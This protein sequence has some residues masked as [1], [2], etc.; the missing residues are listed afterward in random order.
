MNFR[1]FSHSQPDKGRGLWIKA[2]RKVTGK[3][4]ET[5]IAR[6]P[7]HI[8]RTSQL[9]SLVERFHESSEITELRETYCD[10]QGVYGPSCA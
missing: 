6:R 9:Q 7:R 1:S 5:E 2:G 8:S 10:Y 3:E 4:I